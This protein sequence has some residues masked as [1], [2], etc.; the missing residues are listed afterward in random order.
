M[1]YWCSQFQRVKSGEHGSRK[2]DTHGVG[3][4]TNNLHP[5]PKAWE[6]A[7]CGVVTGNCMEF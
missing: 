5:D 3:A 1:V 4:V 7:G 2:P 6:E